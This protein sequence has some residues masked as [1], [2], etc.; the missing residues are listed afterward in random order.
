MGVSFLSSLIHIQV[1]NWSAHQERED[2]P[3]YTWFKFSNNYFIDPKLFGISVGAKMLFILILCERSRSSDDFATLNTDLVA[4]QLRS[5]SVEI[6]RQIDELCSVGVITR[7]NAD[8]AA[9]LR[10]H[11]AGIQPALRRLDKI[12]EDKKR[13]DKKEYAFDFVSVA[14]L[15]PNPKGR[16]VGVK[17]LD[18]LIKT[19]EDFERFS[20]AVKNYADQCRI[21]GTQMAFIKHFSSFVG[22]ERSGHPWEDYVEHTPGIMAE[23]PGKKSVLDVIRGGQ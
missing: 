5:E 19:A 22:T 4:V 7:L 9:A 11:H 18:A 23:Q 17:R 15:Y 21:D 20:K 3:N 10:R 1:V 14:K 2:R 16:S 8:E 13:R 12:R 6:H